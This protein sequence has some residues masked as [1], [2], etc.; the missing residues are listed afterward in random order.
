MARESNC[1]HL[2]MV[3]ADMRFPSVVVFNM[4]R[5][6]YDFVQTPYPRRDG[7]GYS[8]RYTAKTLSNPNRQP[9]LEDIERDTVEIM[10]C[11]LG[12]TLISRR[13]FEKMLDHYANEPEPP[14]LEELLRSGMPRREM[15][16]AAY[17][18]GRQHPHLVYDDFDKFDAQVTPH[19]TVGL[20]QLIIGKDETE[21]YTLLSGEDTSFCAR[22]RALGEQVRM[23][24]GAG[25]PIAHWGEHMYEGRIEQLGLVHV[26]K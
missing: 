21:P 10:G 3:D 18:L 17:E 14:E 22:W 11:G 19:K 25:S 15:L 16:K 4:L 6:G 12:L 7:R 23:Y 1:T 8:I 9:V 2:L 20:F 5:T 13:C 24:V 26:P